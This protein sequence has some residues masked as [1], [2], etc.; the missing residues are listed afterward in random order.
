METI[1]EAILLY[2]FVYWLFSLNSP[3]IKG[4]R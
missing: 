1:A 3:K 2:C 4:Q